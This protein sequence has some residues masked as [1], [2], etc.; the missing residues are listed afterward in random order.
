MVLRHFDGHMENTVDSILSH[1]DKR[2]MDLI[3]QLNRAQA[4]FDMD[5]QLAREMNREEENRV[6]RSMGTEI[7]PTS[8]PPALRR[9]PAPDNSQ[10]GS[11]TEL[12]H[13]FLR[14]PG[15]PHSNV[16]ST[17]ADDEALAMALQN[18]LFMKQIRDDPELAHLSRPRYSNTVGPAVR[19]G[20]PFSSFGRQEHG[21]HDGPR[22][23][24]AL[25]GKMHRNISLAL[26]P[27][28][29]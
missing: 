16:S 12:P 22:F 15:Y 2:P 26:I 1:G 27:I 20:N 4:G 3:E 10:I 24:E 29:S 9:I 14:I 25:S 19:Q 6:S 5:E 21:P 13:D 18:D 8:V 7:S 23:M 17:V 11:R 28:H